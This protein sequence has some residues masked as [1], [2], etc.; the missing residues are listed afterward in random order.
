[1]G[2]VC[3][4]KAQGEAAPKED[5][6]SAS[7]MELLKKEP[8]SEPKPKQEMDAEAVAYVVSLLKDIPLLNKLKQS[9]LNQLARSLEEI[10]IKAGEDIMTQGKVGDDFFIIIDGI[11][12]VIIENEG[13]TNIVA[14]LEKGD[15]CGEQAMISDSM[16]TATIRAQVP[17]V[18]LR[19]DREGFNSILKDSNVRFAKRNHKRGAIAVEDVNN[20]QIDESRDTAKSEEEVLWLLDCMADNLLFEK[21]TIDQQRVLVSY[22][23]KEV[24]PKGTKLIEEG[25]EGKTFYVVIEGTYDIIVDGVG[26]VDE[27][28][29][30]HCT[31]DLA[32][33]YNAP[34]S[35]T[36]LATSDGQVWVTERSTFRKALMDHGKKTTSEH[37]EF[38]RNVE[39]LQPLT[40]SERVLVDQ[41]LQEKVFSKDEV[42][43]AQGDAGDNFYILVKGS[44][45]CQIQ[46]A[47]TGEVEALVLDKPGDFF[48]ERALLTDEPRA[49]TI[50][51]KD[52]ENVC[53]WLNRINFKELL[54]PLEDIMN[55]NIEE[56]EKPPEERNIIGKAEVCDLEEFKVIGIL[57]RGAFG[58]VTLV[59]DPGTGMSYA[60]KAIRKI[61]VVELGQQSHIVNEKEVMRSLN[62]K[63]LV[64]LRATYKDKWRVY[65][66]LDVC[67]G[68]E[69]F[70]ILRK[71]RSFDEPT[72]KFFAACVIDAFEYMHSFHI[73]YRDLKPENLVMHEDGYIKV[74][75][76]G[77]AKYVP[78]KTYTLCGT[79][80]YLA[81]E[82]VTGQGHGKGVD[83]WALGVLI[84]EMIASFPPFYDDEPMMTYRKI[85]S[86]KFKFPKYMSTHSKNLVTR[87]LKVRVTKRLGVINGGATLIKNHEW[88]RGF[89]WDA[90]AEGSLRP[91]IM[92]EVKARDDISNFEK[93]EADDEKV[94]FDLSKVDMSWD[95][96]FE[97]RN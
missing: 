8:Q 77:F 30:G 49:A 51:C 31:G 81:P 88:F 17:V 2:A 26:K 63:F 92:P 96:V 65:L 36:V 29:K 23:Y 18:C 28:G 7:E 3:G 13:E 25:T 19:L 59:V 37:L 56:Y 60:L 83:W 16:R 74:T 43:F 4:C 21:L 71:R 6:G 79:P 45:E 10:K 73:I 24:V 5:G 75:D 9:E 46:N 12:E 22:M 50:V 72:S 39:L 86:C 55:R 52:E 44:V 64:N 93:F 38:L 87:L 53:L 20:F 54:G 34:R 40:S 70:T 61:Q 97:K 47:D 84:Y 67:L 89:N 11:C 76:F 48:G 57:G 66:L 90:L 62:S 35:A 27:L 32:L 95:S 33:M 1:M 94:E 41:A 82:I 14:T 69:L 68:G 15:Y 42:V 78:N 91:P 58:T 85:I 80:D